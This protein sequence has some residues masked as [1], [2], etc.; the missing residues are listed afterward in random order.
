MPLDQRMEI[1]KSIKGVSEVFGCIDEDGTITKSL[2]Y[3]K[4]NILAKGGDR[5]PDNMPVS[6]IDMCKKIDC[7]IVYGVGGNKIQSSSQLVKRI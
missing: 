5:R 7:K 4:P 6:E 1:I 3:I 2:E